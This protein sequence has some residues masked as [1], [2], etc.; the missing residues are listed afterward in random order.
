MV[1]EVLLKDVTIS[2][3]FFVTIRKTKLTLHQIVE[4]EDIQFSMRAVNLVSGILNKIVLASY[5]VQEYM[6]IY[7]LWG[8]LRLLLSVTY[9]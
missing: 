1:S 8:L 6:E 2:L 5:P 9:I 3:L 4:V 7:I